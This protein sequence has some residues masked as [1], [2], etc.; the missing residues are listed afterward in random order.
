MVAMSIGRTPL[1]LLA[2]CE[3]YVNSKLSKW[4][5]RVARLGRRTLGR[6]V[7][8]TRRY[9][10]LRSS[11]DNVAR[12]RDALVS[13]QTDLAERF[14]DLAKRYHEADFVRRTYKTW[15]PPGHFYSPYPDLDEVAKRVDRIFD[16]T[17]QPLWID[18]RDA[19][20]LEL[21]ETLADLVD[22]VP[23]PAERG[24]EYR[25]FFDN[26]AYSWGDGI[27]LHAMLRHVRPRRVVEVGSGYSSALMLD[28]ADGWLDPSPE[29]TF[30]EP[31]PELLN[32]LLR[33]A[34]ADRVTI[35][36]TAV[37]D[38]PLEVFSQLQAGDILFIDST[39][40]VKAGSDVNHLFFEVLPRL[41]SGVWIHIHD[42]FFPFEYDIAWVREGRAWQEAYLLRAFLMNNP[43]FE[44]RWFQDYMWTRH[45]QVIEGRLPV[46][47][48]D[49]GANLWLQRT[50][51]PPAS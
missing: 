33:P 31:Y 47:A 1:D 41:A 34:D 17:T 5:Q 40:V 37:Q 43:A 20:Q 46:I 30:V 23:F 29:L 25:Y 26:G 6:Y 42:V 9:L 14:D 51:H 49:V 2:Y 16:P 27:V 7:V 38:L 39:H 21:F 48:K 18:L 24:E 8:P 3:R 35:H 13:A 15:M 22:S 10:E 4:R 28:T 19:A 50:D 12:E 11:Y 36:G 32:S 45:R 44:L